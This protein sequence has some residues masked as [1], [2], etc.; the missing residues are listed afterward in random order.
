MAAAIFSGTAVIETTGTAVQ[1]RSTANSING[2][3][4]KA[5]TNNDYHI[6]VGP[7]SVT[8]DNTAGTAGTTLEAGE[9]MPI[10]GKTETNVFYINGT[11]GDRVDFAFWTS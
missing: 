6:R 11:A 8:D 3:R 4:I 2:G 9:A 7:S 10:T 5:S 1:L